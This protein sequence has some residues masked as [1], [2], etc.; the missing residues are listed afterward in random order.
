MFR[1][2]IATSATWFTI[3]IRLGLAAVMI[4]HGAQKVLGSFNGPGFKTYIGGTTP[5]GFMRPAWLWLA[6]AALSE[7]VGGLLV[8]LGFLTRVGAFFIA[9][10]MVTA[11]GGVHLPNGF[12]AANRGYE[13]PMALLAMALGLLISGGGQASVDKALSGG[14][15]G[16]R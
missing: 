4:A 6:L 15:R 10:V 11:I 2:L 3:P 13:Y 1:R 5:F 9:C 7:L 14:G 12:F 8:G 16:R